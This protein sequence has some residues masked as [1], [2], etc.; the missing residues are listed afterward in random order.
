[1]SCCQSW[2]GFIPGSKKEKYIK[3]IDITS[4]LIDLFKADI[5]EKLKVLICVVVPT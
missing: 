4:P 5:L 3:L 1:M 2:T